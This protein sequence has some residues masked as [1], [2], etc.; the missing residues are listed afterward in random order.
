M[1]KLRIEPGTDLRAKRRTAVRAAGRLALDD[2]ASIVTAQFLPQQ[3]EVA[4]E[5]LALATAEW[6][7]VEGHPDLKLRARIGLE[8]SAT[9]QSRAQAYEDALRAERLR[10]ATDR[11][12][13]TYLQKVVLA[14]PAIARTWWLDRQ[15]EELSKLSW[16][17]FNEKVLPVVGTAD[18]AHSRAMQAAP[19]LAEV[20]EQLAAD[21]GRHKQFIA[22]FRV[23]LEQMG[24]DAA[25][26]K[27]PPE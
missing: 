27:L 11:E 23:V 4:Q 19:V 12:R 15:R 13:L 24:W 2:L 5:Q 1:V 21:P 9:A 10:H 7:E 26:E 20:M 14:D 17:E 16:R 18:D 3:I 8:L 25:A 22:T 6:T